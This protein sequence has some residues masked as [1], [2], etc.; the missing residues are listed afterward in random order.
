MQLVNIHTI[1]FT[2]SSL[3]TTLNRDQT[4]SP[5]PLKK[6]P[7]VDPTLGPSFLGLDKRHQSLALGTG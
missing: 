1:L 2:E 5:V 6:G 4:A 7:Q 3:F